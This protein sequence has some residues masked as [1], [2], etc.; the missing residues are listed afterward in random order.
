MVGSADGWTR[1]GSSYT[2]C[3]V[4]VCF[5]PL[6]TEKDTSSLTQTLSCC[7]PNLVKIITYSDEVS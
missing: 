4:V 5:P 1:D 7:D 6:R 3:R 2:I